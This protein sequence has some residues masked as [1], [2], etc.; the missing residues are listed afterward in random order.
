MG[1]GGRLDRALDAHPDAPGTV[2]VPGERGTHAEVDV[3]RVDR[4]GV[5]VRAFGHDL[6]EPLCVPQTQDELAEQAAV[7]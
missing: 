4:I 7:L 5:R 1:W 3:E 6:D 2:R